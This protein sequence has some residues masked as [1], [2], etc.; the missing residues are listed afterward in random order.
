MAGIAPLFT[1]EPRIKLK[2]NGTDIAF[3]IGMN[4]NVS[5]NA[6][7]VQ[8]LGKF[9]PVSLEPTYYNP[10]TGTM[11]IIRLISKEDLQ[12]A[13]DILQDPLNASYV[14][15]DIAPV[16]KD[17]TDDEGEVTEQ[18]T[19]SAVGARSSNN[20]LVQNSLIR[21]MAP[22]SVLLSTTFDMEMYMRVP[23]PTKDG[24]TEALDQEN[25]ND[26]A[27]GVLDVNSE[28]GALIEVPWM[29]VKDCRITSRNINISQG[30]LIN[31]PVSFQGIFLTPKTTSGN[32]M[33][34]RDSGATVN[35]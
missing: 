5:L 35:P 22:R 33:F 27:P 7:P 29:T 30:Q 26:P 8:I 16:I 25:D 13:T 24:V 1:T 15:S 3:A 19:S 2:I 17:K 31:E 6:Q 18:V 12:N 23:D 20:P 21:H 4:L 14:N 28:N 11:Q 34:F 10:V 32:D 9:G